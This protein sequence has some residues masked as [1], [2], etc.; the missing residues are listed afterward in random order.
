MSFFAYSVFEDGKFKR[1]P[2]CYVRLK[3]FGSAKPTPSRKYSVQNKGIFK[4]KK[5]R[6]KSFELNF[7]Q[8]SG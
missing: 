2:D 7:S 8:G 6:H 4:A 5:N 1:V 3:V